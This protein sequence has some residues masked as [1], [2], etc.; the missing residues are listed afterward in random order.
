MDT[1]LHTG[2]RYEEYESVMPERL[3]LHTH[4]LLSLRSDEYQVKKLL[5]KGGF[6]SVYQI[7]SQK[8]KKLFALKIMNLWEV[9]PSEYDFLK[10]KFLQ[11][12]KA[13]RLKSPH[14]VTSHHFGFIAGNPY[15]IMEYC[16]NGNLERELH[17]FGNENQIDVLASQ[18]LYGLQ[19]LH[20]NGII[21]RDLKPANV[22]FGENMEARITDFD[23]SGHLSK[24]NTYKNIF[25]YAQAVYG[26]VAFC[27]PEQMDPGSYFKMTQPSMDMYAFG[28]TMYYVLSRGHNPYGE[29]S[30]D[31]KDLEKYLHKKR[32]EKPIPITRYNPGV[33]GKWQN[34]LVHCIEP[35]P[36]KR[37]QSV[38]EAFKMLEVKWTPLQ[39][40]SPAE[41]GKAMLTILIGD[42]MGKEYSLD[43]ILKNQTS[44]L[45]R[46]GREGEEQ[47][48]INLKEKFTNYISRRQFV[49]EKTNK[50]WII[51]DGQFCREDDKAYWKN[52]TNG[53]FVN[54]KKV[55]P[56]E[57]QVLQ[58]GD[59]IGVGDSVLKFNL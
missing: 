42:D 40:S 21:H 59:I 55:E 34:L 26:T 46:V 15:I 10:E 20:A 13:G 1:S 51:R 58:N 38:A 32:T 56:S 8:D 12:F 22:L 33:S 25:G 17:V 47:N 48:Q 5:G 28:S 36:K 52:S 14:I 49:M 24:R 19:A 53:T 2:K 43:D 7:E 18:I 54:H 45:I 39:T 41:S 6:G 29:F 4:D 23:L 57:F 37:I 31:I 30:A 9:Q 44:K 27:P 3:I 35:N 50:H 16:A 11:G